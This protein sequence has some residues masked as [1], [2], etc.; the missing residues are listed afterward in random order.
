MTFQRY[1]LSLGIENLFD[2]QYATFGIEA[3]NTVGGGPNAPVVPFLTPGFTR[4]FTVSAS[5]HL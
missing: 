3:P 2:R 5:V 4:R 1:T